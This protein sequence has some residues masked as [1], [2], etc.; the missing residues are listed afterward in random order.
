MKK[1]LSTILTLSMLSVPVLHAGAADDISV[2]LDGKE[3][4][5]DK[6]PQ[7]MNGRVMVPMR[8]AFEAI[9]A[10]ISWDGEAS[11]ATAIKDALYAKFTNG[12]DEM[13]LG[14]CK[15]GKD[16]GE[17]VY[18]TNEQLDS[19]PVII[20]GT[21]YVP[22]RALAEAFHYNVEWNSDKK[23]AEITTPEDA[24]G[25][26]YYSSWSDNGHMYKADTNGQ[27]RQLLSM[28]DCYSEYW[29]FSYGKGYILYSIRDHENPDNEGALYRIKTDGTG[30]QKLTD[31]PVNVLDD[32][33]S[34]SYGA[35]ENGDLFFI[36]GKKDGAG[37]ISSYEG[38]V[39]LYKLNSETGE[40]T[41]IIDEPISNYPLY[42]YGDYIYFKYISDTI[43]KAYSIYRIDKNG[44]NLI[45]VTGD[46]AVDNYLRFDVENDKIIFTPTGGGTYTAELDGSDLQYEKPD[47]S[48]PRK[49]AEKYG[50]DYIIQNTGKY[51]VG[52][53]YDEDETYYILDSDGNEIR[54]LTAPEGMELSVDVAED[55]IYYTLYPTRERGPKKIYV[56]SID[57]LMG[58]EYIS[59]S[60]EKVD[61]KYEITDLHNYNYSFSKITD[62]AEIHMLDL[63]SMDD[64]VLFKGYYLQY[65]DENTSK[66][67]LV[68]WTEDEGSA[69]YYAD[70]DGNNLT[71]VLPSPSK[72]SQG[73]LNENVHYGIVVTNDGTVKSYEGNS[74]R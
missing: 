19:A 28:D 59:V 72:T 57:E 69:V 36:E 32:S 33:K 10:K 6:A 67:R 46:I 23:T 25:W 52:V 21:M 44:E 48:S 12:S 62:N 11:A 54:K 70:L 9:D 39:H 37:W 71:K 18:Y 43:D 14:V 58:M 31:E 35:D 73:V 60:D 13:E 5:F 64:K 7:I 29:N 4:T 68:Q 66:L 74:F 51:I 49:D 24:D 8:K 40:I 41:Q 3:I 38:D 16:D 53:K 17:Q 15:D 56:D 2:T 1:L 61:G 22:M 30:K 50:L 65:V 45:R 34:G 27:H 55:R 42:I 47:Y 63:N 20:D 26:I